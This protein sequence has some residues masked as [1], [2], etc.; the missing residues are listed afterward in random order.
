MSLVKRFLEWISPDTAEEIEAEAEN[1]NYDKMKV[2][3]LFIEMIKTAKRTRKSI[4][5][6]VVAGELLVK[7]VRG[8][9]PNGKKV[10]TRVKKA[11]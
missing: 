3:D 10:N 7:D 4:D 5:A 6:F 2:D 9:E 11:R 8:V 1:V